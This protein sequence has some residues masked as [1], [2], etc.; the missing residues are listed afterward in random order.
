MSNKQKKDS[1]SIRIPQDY[2][3]K[4]KDLAK[5]NKR[6]LSSELVIILDDYLSGS[7]DSRLG[8]KLK[9]LSKTRGIIKHLPKGDYAR[10]IDRVLYGD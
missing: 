7:A 8:R 9:A 5:N 2:Y 10:T 1:T 4:L 6:P 3:E